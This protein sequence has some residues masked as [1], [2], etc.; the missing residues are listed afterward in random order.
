MTD[1][2]LALSWAGDLPIVGHVHGN[3]DETALLDC[4]R[5]R[6]ASAAFGTP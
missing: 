4:I 3:R 5:V 2:D 6:F 1:D